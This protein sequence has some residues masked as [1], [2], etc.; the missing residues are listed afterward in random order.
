MYRKS[1]FLGLVTSVALFSCRPVLAETLQESVSM[2]LAAHPSV[3]A[4]LAGKD[5]AKENKKEARSG[6]FPTV[7]AG[8]SVGRILSLIHI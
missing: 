3:E 5:I 8:A 7:S 1:I 6:L 4:A 2:A